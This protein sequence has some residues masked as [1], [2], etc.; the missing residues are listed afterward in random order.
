MLI[1]GAFTKF[2][3]SI[4]ISGDRAD[5]GAITRILGIEP[6]FA[7][8]KGAIRETRTGRQI[9]QR[10]GIWELRCSYDANSGSDAR[11]V[12]IAVGAFLAGLPEEPTVWREVA[13]LGRI[14]VTVTVWFEEDNGSALFEPGLFARLATMGASLLV[15][16][17]QEAPGKG[18]V[19]PSGTDGRE[20]V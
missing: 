4:E 5:P 13:A 16:V 3:V 7:C 15:D 19:V 2:D 12:G 6:T 9:A 10:T 17:W 8:A 1:G 20:A 14:V 11:D 18:S